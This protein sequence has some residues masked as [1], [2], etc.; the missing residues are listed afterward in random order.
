MHNASSDD[1][2]PQNVSEWCEAIINELDAVLRVLEQVFDDGENGSRHSET[3]SQRQSKTS[4]T[5]VLVQPAARPLRTL[6]LARIDRIFSERVEVYG[7]VDFNK[8]SV[9]TTL[10]KSVVR[11]MTEE[12]RVSPI[13]KATY[14]QLQVDLA[15]LKQYLW[16]FCHDERYSF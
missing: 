6:N 9:M 11:G 10:T 13:E 14:Q 15:Y 4:S 7:P 2:P 3:T 5:S 16:P 8:S 1:R 12:F